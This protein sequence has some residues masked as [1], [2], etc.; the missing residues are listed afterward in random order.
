[1][2]AI[3]ELIGPPTPENEKRLAMAVLKAISGAMPLHREKMNED[4]RRHLA[5][6]ESTKEFH[7]LREAFISYVVS[8]SKDAGKRESENR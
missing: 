1:M 3:E 8:S 2:E 6:M 7:A 4:T 5:V